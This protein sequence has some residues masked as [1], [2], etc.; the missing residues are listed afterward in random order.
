MTVLMNQYEFTDTAPERL[1]VFL[2]NQITDH[3]RSFVQKLILDGHVT[4][5]QK[6]QKSNYKLCN[7]DYIEVV[8]P[9]PQAISIQAEDLPLDILYED[10][11][12]IVINK[13][14]GMIVHPA[15][16]IY[17][18]TLVNALLAHCKDLLELMGKFVLELCIGWIKILQ[19]L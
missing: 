8:V 17:S 4:V 6:L 10:Q 3:S 18:G 11:H 19:A 7:G 13:A 15:S 5:N 12:I 1:D 16:G 9:E 14:R 2:T